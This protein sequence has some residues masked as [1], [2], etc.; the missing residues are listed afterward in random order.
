[1]SKIEYSVGERVWPSE[2]K[3][4]ICG[5]FIS[6]EVVNY[7]CFIVLLGTTCDLSPQYNSFQ[8]IKEVADYV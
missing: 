1:M 2:V 6:L 4:A 8:T 7:P 3:I 5:P